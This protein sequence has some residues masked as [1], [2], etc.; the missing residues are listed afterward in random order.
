[1][2]VLALNECANLSDYQVRDSMKTF[3][4]TAVNHLRGKGT[5]IF[6][7][8]FDGKWF[9]TG[10]NRAGV[11]EFRRLLGVDSPGSRQYA[12][13]PRIFYP[14][15][16]KKAK[17]IFL[18]PALLKVSIYFIRCPLHNVLISHRF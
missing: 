8:E 11:E 2:T 4:S 12:L 6:G 15:D 13:F 10:Y 14:N 1:M 3:R 5:L 7:S 16:D 18:N 9:Q 17:D